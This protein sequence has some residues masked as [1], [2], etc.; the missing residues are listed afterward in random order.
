MRLS[1]LRLRFLIARDPIA[2]YT[3]NTITCLESCAYRDGPGRD[4]VSALTA[5][6]MPCAR[7]PSRCT[8]PA[9]YINPEAVRLCDR[10]D[11]ASE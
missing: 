11:R 10:S 6:L 4:R 2:M 3:T 1:F 7:A 9:S 5:R 8:R